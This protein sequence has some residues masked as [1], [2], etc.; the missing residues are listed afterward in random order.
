[1]DMEC[2]LIVDEVNIDS[3]LNLTNEEHKDR[4]CLVHLKALE[5]QEED[6]GDRFES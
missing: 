2:N 4:T 3:Y 6:Q 1:M 5:D